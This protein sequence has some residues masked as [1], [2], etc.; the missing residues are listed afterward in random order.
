[1]YIMDEIEEFLNS[2]TDYKL[3]TLEIKHIERKEDD[4]ILLLTYLNN[5][6]EKYGFGKRI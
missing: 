3:H 5:K 6:N 4:S 1:M 2:L